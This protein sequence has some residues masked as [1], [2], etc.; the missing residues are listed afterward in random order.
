MLFKNP[1]E[2]LS[3][4]AAADLLNPEIS[5]EVKD[6]VE[7][8]EDVL[9]NNIEEVK[10]KDKT[11]N[12][13]IPVTTQGAPVM[14]AACT[15]G[16]AGKYLVTIESVIAICEE[17]AAAAEAET[18]VEEP[19]AE[20]PGQAPAEIPEADPVNVIEKIAADNGVEPEQVKVV[21]SSESAKYFSEMAILE[22]K[23]G[24]EDCNNKSLG[25]ARK[26]A[27]AA[28]KLAEAGYLVKV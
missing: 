6:V 19:A 24:K 12:G 23:C 27:S 21:I 13:G 2:L 15:Y 3:E 20:E 11:T 18:P 9:T 14:E 4:S 17:E 26:Y 22:S 1:R 16:A 10:D 28:K 8:L 7:E 25:L 5:K